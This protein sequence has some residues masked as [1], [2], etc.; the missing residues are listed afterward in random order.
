VA[1]PEAERARLGTLI[2]RGEVPARRLTRARILLKANQGAGD[3]GGSDAVIAGAVE[4]PPTTAARVRRAFV[5][6]A[7]TAARARQ[8]PDPEDA[9]KGGPPRPRLRAT[10][11]PGTTSGAAIGVRAS[12]G[13]SCLQELVDGPS[14]AAAG[15]VRGLDQRATHAPLSRDAAV[16]PA[17]TTPPGRHAGAPCPPAHGA[18]RTLAERELSI[19]ARQGLHRRRDDHRLALHHGGDPPQA[20]TALPRS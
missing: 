14:P 1:R 10:A 16:P 5:Q 19:L 7:L 18:W 15:I 17:E 4:G 12:T 3:P 6:D 11:R 8:R 9:R 20:P 13:S 2:G